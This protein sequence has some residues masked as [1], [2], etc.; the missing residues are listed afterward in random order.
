[1]SQPQIFLSKNYVV[2]S[3]YSL[4]SNVMLRL[5]PYNK[6]FRQWA[7]VLEDKLFRL[8]QTLV[9]YHMA[10]IGVVSYYLT[11]LLFSTV[12]IC[13]RWSLLGILFLEV[14]INDA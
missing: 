11:D 3:V 5:S 8:A 2:H 6:L 4:T 14:T 1:M 12:S 9:A 10:C 7:Q 13:Y